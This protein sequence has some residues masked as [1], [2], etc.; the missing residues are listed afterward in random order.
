[1]GIQDR[2]HPSSARLVYH[3]KKHR[4]LAV[5]RAPLASQA[6][7]ASLDTSPSSASPPS[8]HLSRAPPPGGRSALLHLCPPTRG[9][10]SGRN[11]RFRAER[12]P[13]LLQFTLT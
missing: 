9:S 2:T 5:G 1:M 11:G 3:H 10:L 8:A 12:E 7:N 6:E 13:C 4:D